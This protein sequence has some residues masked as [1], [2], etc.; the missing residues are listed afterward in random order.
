MSGHRSPA[1]TA[2]TTGTSVA[3][4]RRRG[5]AS[6]LQRAS[7]GRARATPRVAEKLPR[8]HV[9]TASPAANRPCALRPGGGLLVDGATRS[10]SGI[11]AR[12]LLATTHDHSVTEPAPHE[13]PGCSVARPL[14]QMR[15]IHVD[16][17]VGAVES[18]ST[19][20]PIP[21]EP[22]HGAGHPSSARTEAC[23]GWEPHPCRRARRSSSAIVDTVRA[24]RSAL[25][26]AIDGRVPCCVPRRAGPE[27]RLPQRRT[28]VPR[29]RERCGL[30]DRVESV[31]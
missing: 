2:V 1:T 31:Q 7:A 13:R 4:S 9:R 16:A 6:G 14:P 17:H 28:G 24:L 12:P 27:R 19:P 11:G 21:V 29:L 23:T 15:A 8:R 30:H 25:R 18:A 10:G 3:S 22:R 5:A 26:L 20:E